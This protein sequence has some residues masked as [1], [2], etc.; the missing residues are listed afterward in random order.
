M[1]HKHY[2]SLALEQAKIA[3]QKQ[4]VP[5][6]A[7]LVAPNGY[8]TYGHNARIYTNNPTGHAE[9]LAICDMSKYLNNYRLQECSLY[10]TL[11]PC[12]M[13]SGLINDT[14]IPRVYYGTH[15]KINFDYLQC[16]FTLKGPILQQECQQLLDAFFKN[17]R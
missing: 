7:V 17:R 8:I 16:N 12:M 1:N 9:I 4:E 3:Y 5:V 13:C 11:Q 2:M 15:S 10:V 6:G 14:R